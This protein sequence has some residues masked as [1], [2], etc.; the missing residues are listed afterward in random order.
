MPGTNELMTV[1]PNFKVDDPR[2]NWIPGDINIKIT[3]L[4]ERL[5]QIP[6]KLSNITCKYGAECTILEKS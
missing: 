6:K 1:W 4:A 2:F 3:N 5:K